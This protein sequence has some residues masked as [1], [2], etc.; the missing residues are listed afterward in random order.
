MTVQD[1]M[2]VA[3]HAVLA[4]LYM[5]GPPLL[6]AMAVGLFVAILQAAT[7]IQETSLT[8]VPKI[9]AIGLTLIFTGRWS[10]G[11]M[12]GFVREI[13]QHFERLGP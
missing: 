5:I 3:S 11:H 10:L 7:Q 8:F 1:V 6:A 4:I 12:M 13:M 9:A 2:E